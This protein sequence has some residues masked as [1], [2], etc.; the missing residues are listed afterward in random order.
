MKSFDIEI[1]NHSKPTSMGGGYC[2][3]LN[4]LA[5]YAMNTYI[6][7]KG[8]HAPGFFAIDSAL[9]QLSEAEYI[10]AENSV[11]HSFMNFFISNSLDRQ[12][13]MVEQK[14]EIPFV[15]VEDTT[16][17]IHVIEFS[18]NPEFGRYGFLNDVVNPEH[19]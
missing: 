16:K 11:K 10:T 6:Y 9:T 15:P 8:G 12:V 19:K 5:V 17:G 13:I 18:R 4:T 14:D 3:I 1:D 7:S 2:A